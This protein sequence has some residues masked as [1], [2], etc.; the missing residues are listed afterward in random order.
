MA[1]PHLQQPL[2]R[3]GAPLETAAA[4]LVLLHGRGA[5]AESI[6]PLGDAL[7]RDGLAVL[8][9]QAAMGA[10]YPTTFLAPLRF[11]EAHLS[12]A[13]EAVGRAVAVAEA[14]GLAR[15]RIVLAGFSQG[16]C[17]ASEYAAR[18]AGRWGGLLAFSGGLIGSDDLPGADVPDDKAFEYAG[19]FEGMPAFL[20]CSDVDPHIPLARVRQ[21]ARVLE[22]LDA[23]VDARVYP[24]FGHSI[25]DDEIGAAR[26]L[27]AGLD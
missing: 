21:T 26:A 14:A 10:W 24:G 18:H 23:S 6:L 2:R 11:N 15:E 1:H 7:G 22:R 17:L 19:S 12:A 13:L 25:N 20:G 8:A 5:T 4:A 9:P 27:L 3:G 16:A